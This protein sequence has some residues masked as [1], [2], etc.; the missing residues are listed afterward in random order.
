MYNKKRA[1]D[2]IF[3]LEK[4]K[5]CKKNLQKY[6]VAGEDDEELCKKKVVAKYLRW[7]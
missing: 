5:T 1:A 4:K 2:E 7:L 6:F 3:K